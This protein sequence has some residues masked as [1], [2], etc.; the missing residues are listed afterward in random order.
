M[1][2]GQLNYLLLP[3]PVLNNSKSSF[4]NWNVLFNCMI[5]S[6]FRAL[7][8]PLYNFS[9]PF[10]V[11]FFSGVPIK[12][13]PLFFI[14][15]MNKLIYGT[16]TVSFLSSWVYIIR[17]VYLEKESYLYQFEAQ[18]IDLFIRPSKVQSIQN[19]WNIIVA[20]PSFSSSLW[21]SVALD[22]SLL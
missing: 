18:Q 7:F 1:V 21:K 3:P 12:W 15:Q 5:D 19:A 9:K 22:C 2:R 11:C 20:S 4:Y 16:R 13:K 6:P 8:F 17:I 10:F 14:Y